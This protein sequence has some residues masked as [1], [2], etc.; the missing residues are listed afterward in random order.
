MPDAI[1]LSSGEI[2]IDQTLPAGQRDDDVPRTGHGWEG[3]TA[4]DVTLTARDSNGLTAS[5]TIE[6]EPRKVGVPITANVPGVVVT[7][8]RQ[9]GEPIGRAHP[10]DVVPDPSVRPPYQRGGGD[11]QCQR[12]GRGRSRQ[13]ARGAPAGN[14]AACHAHDGNGEEGRGAIGGHGR[15]PE[16]DGGIRVD[17]VH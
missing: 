6:L 16:G 10:D 13:F 1:H 4:F 9:G 17:E 8:D 12:H 15:H 11:P 3:Q 14:G 2:A 7:V 5:T